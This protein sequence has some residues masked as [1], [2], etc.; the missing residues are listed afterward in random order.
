M[1]KLEVSDSASV[2]ASSVVSGG[3]TDSLVCSWLFFSLCGAEGPGVTPR[4]PGRKQNRRRGTR[5]QQQ[6]GPAAHALL[7]VRCL[8]QALGNGEEA[9]Q[10]G[11]TPPTTWKGP[12]MG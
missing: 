2:S 5:L 4:L 8:Q 11:T 7:L 1:F 3:D 10:G 12:Y 9:F 6:R